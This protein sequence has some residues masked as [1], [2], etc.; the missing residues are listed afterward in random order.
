MAPVRTLV[1]DVVKKTQR[2]IVIL[3]AVALLLT[4][5]LLVGGMPLFDACIHAFGTAGTGGFGIL[6]SSVA[7]YNTATQ[8]I[9]SVIMIL[10]GVNFGCYYLILTKRAKEVFRNEEL[11]VYLGV[12]LAAIAVVTVNIVGMFDSVGE[13]LKH[14]L[15]QVSSVMTTTGFS[16]TDFDLW[17]SFSKAILLML[18]CQLP[19]SI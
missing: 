16:T 17:P 4:V 2:I 7:D 5:L 14:A 1:T 18:I 3:L 11:R 19:G 8:I 9:L 12:M 6:S 10:C 15:F 13:A